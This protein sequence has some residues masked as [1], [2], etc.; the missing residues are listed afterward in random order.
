MDFSE[1]ES[2][3]E[4]GNDF[5]FDPDENFDNEFEFLSVPDEHSLFTLDELEELDDILN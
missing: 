1:F 5:D 3:D 2:S 4:H